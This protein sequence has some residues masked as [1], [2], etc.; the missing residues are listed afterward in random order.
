MFDSYKSELYSFGSPWIV[1]KCSK[2]GAVL[3]HSAL[4]LYNHCTQIRS[5]EESRFEKIK[6]S[7]K[8]EVEVV[9]IVDVFH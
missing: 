7:S 3:G 9:R 6:K 2:K 1:L 4:N 5:S 8:T